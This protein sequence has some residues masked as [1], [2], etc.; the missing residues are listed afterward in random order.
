[1]H[2]LN[3]SCSSLHMH[4][5]LSSVH[6]MSYSGMHSVIM[7]AHITINGIMCIQY[8]STHTAM[9]TCTALSNWGAH[10]STLKQHTRVLQWLPWK[11][12][13]KMVSMETDL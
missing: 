6:N 11:H 7:Y 2:I 12:G 10:P 5:M 8:G 13:S 1:M 3:T 4:N 9:P